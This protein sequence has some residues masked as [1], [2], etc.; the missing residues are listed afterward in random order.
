MK[1]RLPAP[2]RLRVETVRALEVV[3]GA[4]AISQ[5]LAGYCRPPLP[6]ESLHC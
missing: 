3:T 1:K 5:T 6:D 4:I 2:L